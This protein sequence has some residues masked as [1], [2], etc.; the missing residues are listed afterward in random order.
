VIAANIA[1]PAFRYGEFTFSGDTLA[2]LLARLHPVVVHFPVAL[3]IAAAAFEL[4]YVL[5]RRRGGG[6][7]RPHISASARGCL[8]MGV[9][10]AGVA[11]WSGWVRQDLDP[12][13]S[14]LASAVTLHRWIAIAAGAAG[15]A[16]LLLS[17]PAWRSVRAARA[18]RLLLVLSAALVGVAGHFGGSLVWGSDYFTELLFPA[19]EPMPAGPAPNGPAPIGPAVA[20]GPAELPGGG[21]DVRGVD[22]SRD[23]EPIFALYCT[24]CHGQRRQKGRLRLDRRDSILARE[25]IVPGDPESSELIRRVRLDPDDDDF[26]PR[27]D[28]PLGEEQIALLSAWIAAGAPWDAAGSAAAPETAPETG[29]EPAVTADVAAPALPPLSADQRGALDRLAA[30]GATITPITLDAPDLDAHLELL[31]GRCTDAQ[32]DDLA[33]LG[34]RLVW[35]NLAGTGVTDATAVRLAGLPRLERLHLERTAI[36]DAGV[37]ALRP[38]EHLRYLNLYATGVTDGCLASL[39]AMPALEEVFLWGSGVSERG[40]DLLRRARPGLKVVFSPE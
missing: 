27:D 30:L 19:D 39:A 26:M 32:A 16:A 2:E 10:G 24:D 13:G 28:D 15:A 18:Y 36:T 31:G 22:F 37:D 35:L 3:L 21:P 14:S 17:V 11:A 29:P 8:V 20:A 34:D 25:A 5:F 38:L 33:A 6:P 9:L 40:A 7:E 23:I 4:L 12:L 1:E